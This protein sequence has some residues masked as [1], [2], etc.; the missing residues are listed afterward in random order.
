MNDDEGEE[1]SSSDELNSTVIE[2]PATFEEPNFASDLPEHEIDA[3][4][5]SSQKDPESSGNDD[6]TDV[7]QGKN[8]YIKLI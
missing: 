3:V 4:M 6:R 8:V 5:E 7:D 2:V 1:Q